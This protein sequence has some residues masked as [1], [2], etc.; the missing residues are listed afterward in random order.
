MVKYTEYQPYTQVPPGEIPTGTRE[1]ATAALFEASFNLKGRFIRSGHH[2][3]AMK[4]QMEEELD[5]LKKKFPEQPDHPVI[6]KIDAQIDALIAFYNQ[7]D[8]IINDYQQLFRVIKL[9][10]VILESALNGA[11]INR[12][13]IRKSFL[14]LND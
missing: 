5:R 3:I 1:Q 8:E 11:V 12:Q 14:N 9:Q 10:N 6:L 13:E 4:E 7:C 2:I